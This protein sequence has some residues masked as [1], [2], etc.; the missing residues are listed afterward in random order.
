MYLYP[1]IQEISFHEGM[2]ENKAFHE[3]MSENKQSE[4]L[5]TYQQ[6][7]LVYI[8]FDFCFKIVNVW[9]FTKIPCWK[10]RKN[11]LIY[12]QV[13][14]WGLVHCYE[15]TY[16]TMYL[17][18]WIQEFHFTSER[19]KKS[20]NTSSIWMFARQWIFSS[21]CSSRHWCSAYWHWLALALRAPAREAG[22]MPAW[23]LPRP[24]S[25][26]QSESDSRRCLA[27]KTT[28]AARPCPATMSPWLG[29][30]VYQ[31]TLPCCPV[32]LIGIWHWLS[33][34]PERAC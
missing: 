27:R 16:E 26:C 31:K 18:P 34:S 4:A 7:E 28:Y 15:F 13:L 1:W 30:L 19:V 21:W 6:G 29:Q 3:R 20:S 9:K 24:T 14:A 23:G 5:W 17:Y 2:S 8:L 11:D 32:R 25:S 33:L 12:A 22:H 10:F